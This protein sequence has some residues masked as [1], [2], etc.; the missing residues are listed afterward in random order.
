LVL[1]RWTLALAW[2]ATLARV[3]LTTSLTV[4]HVTPFVTS[5]VESVRRWVLTPLT[6]RIELSEFEQARISSLDSTSEQDRGVQYAATIEAWKTS[7]AG[8][9]SPI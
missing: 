5:F 6:K 8:A 9:I 3:S 4:R 7:T 2:L 1:S